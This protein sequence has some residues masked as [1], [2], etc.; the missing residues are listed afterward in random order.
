MHESDLLSTF[1]VPVFSG[2]GTRTYLVARWSP[3]GRLTAQLKYGVTRYED[4][5]SVGSGLDETAGNR[6]REARVLLAWSL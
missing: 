5:P 6:L 4:V 1:S 3:T 2:R